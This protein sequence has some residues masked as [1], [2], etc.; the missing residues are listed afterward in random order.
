MFVLGKLKW[1][2]SAVT[3]HDFLEQILSRLPIDRRSFKVLKR[4]AQT[5]IA[6][7][8]TGENHFISFPCPPPYL[9]HGFRHIDTGLVCVVF[10]PDL[11]YVVR[12][13]RLH[14]DHLG[15]CI[16]VTFMPSFN[17]RK[18]SSFSQTGWNT[19]Q[20]ISE[21]VHVEYAALTRTDLL[22]CIWPCGALGCYCV[23]VN[24]IYGDILLCKYGKHKLVILPQYVWGGVVIYPSFLG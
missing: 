20:H 21:C 16:L 1:D 10:V 11:A 9:S 17:P 12:L 24:P 15:V 19:A 22:Q 14:F 3:P 2:I 8:A 6:L 23:D 5:F 13:Q 7:C 4:H 18:H